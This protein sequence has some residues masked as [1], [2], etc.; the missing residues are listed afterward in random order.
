M[1]PLGHLL[2]LL[3]ISLQSFAVESYNLEQLIEVALNQNLSLQIEK[4][5]ISQK[6]FSKIDS[7]RLRWPCLSMHGSTTKELQKNAC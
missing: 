1:K 4:E 2:F 6:E 5:V 3:S 7:D